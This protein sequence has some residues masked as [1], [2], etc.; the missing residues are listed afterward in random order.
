ML[1]A[2]TGK[3]RRW[4][5]C[6]PARYQW[7]RVINTYGPRKHL[8]FV[9][10]EYQ[11]IFK[12]LQRCVSA[13]F[14]LLYL[15]SRSCSVPNRPDAEVATSFR[16]NY[17][18]LSKGIKKVSWDQE[19]KFSRISCYSI[20]EGKIQTTPPCCKG[21]TRLCL[22]GELHLGLP[23]SLNGGCNG[24][25]VRSHFGSAVPILLCASGRDSELS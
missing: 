17:G 5:S 1:S 14:V 15:S 8:H 11:L 24:R 22:C 13:I 25:T 21:R 19:R 10:G 18:M 7:P 2:V 3:R 6:W 4:A 16:S 9:E 23:F 20:Q 12:A